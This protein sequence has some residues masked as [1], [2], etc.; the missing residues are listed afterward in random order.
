[1]YAYK[2]DYLQQKK[3]KNDSKKVL[4]YYLFLFRNSESELSYSVSERE[5]PREPAKKQANPYRKSRQTPI[6]KAGKPL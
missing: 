3:V 2:I 5:K 6:E 1:M 4:F